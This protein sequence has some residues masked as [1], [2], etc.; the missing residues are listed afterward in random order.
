M[1]TFKQGP[2]V[3]WRLWCEGTRETCAAD[4]HSRSTH[5]RQVSRWKREPDKAGD[6]AD[7]NRHIG[8]V[9]NE[10]RMANSYTANR[11]TWK[12]T[13]KLFFST[14]WTWPFTTFSHF[15]LMWWEENL[16]DFRLTII[17]E[18]LARAG[19]EPRPPMPVGR[20]AQTSTNIGRFDTSHNKH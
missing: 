14:R 16:T 9:D 2:K 20:P 5:R 6:L 4:K 17:R 8:H 18:M 7:Y 11:W 1:V 15:F 12:W 19:H 13:K 3:T 10:D